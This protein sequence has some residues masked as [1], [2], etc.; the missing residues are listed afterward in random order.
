MGVIH[1]SDVLADEEVERAEDSKKDFEMQVP[2]NALDD[3]SPCC[4][5]AVDYS[6]GVGNPT[7]SNCGKP[8]YS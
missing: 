6:L 4:N 3:V 7:C 8:I 2:K 5:S 1:L